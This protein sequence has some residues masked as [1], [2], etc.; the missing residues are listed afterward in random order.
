MVFD[1]AAE[2]NGNSL[3]KAL[4]TGP[5]LLNSLVGVILQFHSYRVTFSADI[6]AMYQQ[7]QVNSDDADALSFLWLEDVKSDEKPD[8]YQMLVHIFGRKDLPSWANYAVRKT[9]SD[10]GSKLNA[11]VTECVNR[12]FYMDDL[13]NNFETEEQTVSIIKQSS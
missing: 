6:E 11:A 9:V 13:L 1:V 5:K 10:H 8:T 12:S 2:Y 4:L 3:N 7:V